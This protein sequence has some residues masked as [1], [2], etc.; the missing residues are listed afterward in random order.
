MLSKMPV[1]A[2]KRFEWSDFSTDATSTLGKGS[3][4]TVIKANHQRRGNPK[5]ELVAIKVIDA[6]LGKSYADLLQ[7]ADHE[8]EMLMEA[9]SRILSDSNIVKTFGLVAGSI[10]LSPTVKALLGRSDDEIV[11]VVMSFEVGG[12]LDNL[13][14]A[15]S[16]SPNQELTMKDKLHILLDISNGLAMIHSQGI[17]HK[18]LK[19]G[20]VLIS[21]M[22]EIL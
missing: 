13:L 22:G 16:T 4:G 6:K 2:S 1:S 20:N 12:S 3:F 19:P 8:V 11:G 15:T 14:Y 9:Q 21:S 7:E 5:K 18:D 17:V 10:S